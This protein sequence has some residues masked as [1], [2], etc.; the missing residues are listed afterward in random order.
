MEIQTF[1]DLFVYKIQ[2][3][4]DAVN[5]IIEAIPTM[6]DLA[7]SQDLKN[8]L[9]KH[10][11]ETD[12]QKEKLEKLSDDMEIDL[13][14][15]SSLA[16]EGILDDAMELLQDNEPSPIADAALIAAAQV[17]EHYKISSY[18]SAAEWAEQMQ[19]MEAQKVLAELLEEEK[20]ADKALSQLAESRINKQAAQ[21]S[22]QIAMG[23]HA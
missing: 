5:Q 22:G 20:N 1:H 17:I 2:S 14:G 10:L 4:Y 13:E 18:G 6:I 11:K 7:S 3:I 8:I 21:A 16:M 9:V 15:T 12:R 19:H 23:R